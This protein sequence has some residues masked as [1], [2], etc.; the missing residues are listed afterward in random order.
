MIFKY[1][2]VLIISILVVVIPVYG[3]WNLYEIID[4]KKF[5]RIKIRYA[6]CLFKAFGFQDVS[7]YG[8]LIPM[9]LLQLLSYPLSLVT[10]V[11]GVVALILNNDPLLLLLILLGVEISIFVIITVVLAIVSKKRSC[12]S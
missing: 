10:T 11:Y 3:Q 4:D 6:K 7:E 1:L 2:A 5:K 12:N 9:F 8:L